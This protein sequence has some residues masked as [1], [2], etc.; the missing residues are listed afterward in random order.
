VWQ[1]VRWPLAVAGDEDG[2]GE[3]HD[4]CVQRR[5]APP[6]QF[7]GARKFAGWFD[8]TFFLAFE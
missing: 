3:R 4:D 8:T 1:R 7:L 2:R 6:V 5:A